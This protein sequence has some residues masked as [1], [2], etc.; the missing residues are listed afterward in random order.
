MI[1]ILI[2]TDYEYKLTNDFCWFALQS[3]KYNEW[4][5]NKQLFN[6]KYCF[7]SE[8]NSSYKNHIPI[9]SI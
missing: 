1:N 4:Y 3:I 8:L 7:I 5:R 9:G 2:E 6:V